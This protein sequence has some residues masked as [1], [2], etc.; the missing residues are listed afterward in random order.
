MVTKK[1]SLFGFSWYKDNYLY[2]ELPLPNS[3]HLEIKNQSPASNTNDTDIH[4]I[5][6]EDDDYPNDMEIDDKLMLNFDEAIKVKL[7]S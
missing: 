3:F 7:F 4:D 2:L 5:V 6:S 1:V